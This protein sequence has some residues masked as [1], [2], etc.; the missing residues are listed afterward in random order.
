MAGMRSFSQRSQSLINAINAYERDHSAPPGS[1][2]DLV[3]DYLPAV[4][5]TGM[6]AYPEYQYYTDD[7]AK[8]H[9][10]DNPWALSVFTPG[11]GINFDMMLY[12]PNQ[13]Y[14]D[15]GYGGG[16]ERVGDW[17]YVHE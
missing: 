16:L 9:Y 8:E 1:L 5:S 14:P 7:E 10:A 2:D 17:A 3:P 13:N 11:G 6:M 15:R 4:P 12:F